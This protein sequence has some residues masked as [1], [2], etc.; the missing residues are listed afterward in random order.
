M[1]NDKILKKFGSG[2]RISENQKQFLR[3]HGIGVQRV[4]NIGMSALRLSLHCPLSPTCIYLTTTETPVCRMALPC[5][6]SP[7]APAQEKP[8]GW[9]LCPIRAAFIGQKENLNSALIPSEQKGIII[10]EMCGQP[11]PRASE[12]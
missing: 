12:Y 10:N 9:M 3:E 8:L 4:F 6:A 1:S 2:I 7:H 11:G 5:E